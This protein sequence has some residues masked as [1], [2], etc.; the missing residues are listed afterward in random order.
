[1]SSRAEVSLQS[2]EAR[3]I[4][5]IG[6]P[7][8]PSE[9]EITPAMVETVRRRIKDPGGFFTVRAVLREDVYESKFGD[10]FY[11]HVKGIALNSADADK[12]AALAP[13]AEFTKW[14]MRSYRLGLK[15]DEPFFTAL[16]QSKEEFTINRFVEILCEITPGGT[17]SKLLTGVRHRKDDPL[18]SLP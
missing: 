15:D 7:E 17:A 12:L 5:R 9:T 18:L 3:N 8:P 6:A 14:H 10:R 2:G 11:L 13:D 1:M 16:W 4:L